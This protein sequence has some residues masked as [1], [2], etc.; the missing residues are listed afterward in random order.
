M[1]LTIFFPD[2]AFTFEIF[3][4]IM[5]RLLLFFFGLFLVIS[6]AHPTRKALNP[7]FHP[8]R[9][10][11]E[12]TDTLPFVAF[13]FGNAR[14]ENERIVRSLGDGEVVHFKFRIEDGIYPAK[15]CFQRL[16]FCEPPEFL[17]IWFQSSGLILCE[18]EYVGLDTIDPILAEHFFD[19]EGEHIVPVRLKVRPGADIALVHRVMKK[20]L[21][22]YIRVLNTLTNR[23]S[24]QMFFELE[25]FEQQQLIRENPLMFVLF[26][27]EPLPPPFP[28]EYKT[29]L[30]R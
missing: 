18:W 26:Y 21:S 15:A 9:L 3:S 27:P 1:L 14:S 22:A 20:C 10:L 28:A 5:Y 4:T 7:N 19:F 13:D 6:C 25:Y 2:I 17:D 11:T 12:A 16:S 30:N 23:C 29:Q 24:G 8:G